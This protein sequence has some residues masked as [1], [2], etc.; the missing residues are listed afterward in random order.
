[1][2]A[3]VKKGNDSA[4]AL[5]AVGQD[6]AS[7][8]LIL[9]AGKKDKWLQS[10]AAPLYRLLSEG[11]KAMIHTGELEDGVKLPTVREL[12]DSLN[13]SRGTVK[14]AYNSLADDGYLMLK[15]GRGT[16][17]DLPETPAEPQMSRKDRAMAS[18][19][20]MLNE[21]EELGFSRRETQIFLELKL[22]ERDEHSSN[23]K[24]AVFAESPEER[25]LIL[26]ELATIPGVE[27]YAYPAE[28]LFSGR[29]DTG[30]MDLL[31]TTEKTYFSLMKN[32]VGDYSEKLA[33]LGLS[34]HP[35]TLIDLSR[36]EPGESVGILSMSKTYAGKM[37]EQCESIANLNQLP[38]VCLFQQEGLSEFL[39]TSDRVIVP[40]EYLSYM[41]DHI[42]SS[43]RHFLK[44]GGKV[45]YFRTLC[46]KSSLLALRLR[47]EQMLERKRNVYLY[48]H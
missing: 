24:L 3:E 44:T 47:L 16:F 21:M 31:I 30:M 28:D 8:S 5:S 32:P 4:N 43:W 35:Q 41:T 48:Q 40:V 11:I 17:V 27:L 26:N 7:L 39:R 19:D 36:I 14:H 25:S 42:Q 29:A 1:M 38:A 33:L 2:S 23:L 20:T 45:L 22:R 37:L 13:L 18:I 9:R 6:R 34:L 12:A 10:G 15:Q 46:E